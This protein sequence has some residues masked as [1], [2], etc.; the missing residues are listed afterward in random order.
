MPQSWARAL[1]YLVKAAAAGS[2]HAR[3]QLVTLA[4]SDSAGL[5]GDACEE[6][7]AETW[8]AIAASVRVEDWLAPSKKRVLRE[9]PR[10]VAIEGFLSRP[11]AAWLI[12]C[13]EGRLARALV[14][15]Q[16][17]AGSTPTEARSNTAFEFPFIDCDL[18]VLLTRARIAATIGVPVSALEPSQILHYEIGEEFAL[19]H[20]YLDPREA[21]LSADIAAH[22]Q[23]IVTF[24]VYLNDDFTGGE[25]DFPRLALRHRGRAGDALYFGNIDSAGDPDPRTLH[26]GLS[27][28]IGEKWLFSQWIRNRA[29]V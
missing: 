2:A 19:H 7:N 4:N 16:A 18:V 10:T 15:N 29:V 25:T 8:G 13:A 11:I 22:G 20:D 21:G 3:G 1:G 28:K 27:P 17:D 5:A 6:A 23:R 14:Y 12:G 9:S 24:L 26:A